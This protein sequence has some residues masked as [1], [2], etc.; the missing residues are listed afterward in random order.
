MIIR[1]SIVIASSFAAGAAS[2]GTG[3]STTAPVADSLA[4]STNT[5]IKET[6]SFADRVVL[7][8]DAAKANLWLNRHFSPNWTPSQA[9]AD[10]AIKQ[11]ALYL[12]E[13]GVTNHAA[14]RELQRLSTMC[15]Q[16]VS[17]SS[18]GQPAILLNCFMVHQSGSEIWKTRFYRQYGVGDHWSILYLP[19]KRMFT[20]FWY[21]IENL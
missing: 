17:V 19:D 5:K 16:I 13:T 6:P 12:E 21:W 20:R 4:C 18:E 10:D 1:V 15:C 11:L 3:C 8:Q 9:Q 7:A 2:V 14:R